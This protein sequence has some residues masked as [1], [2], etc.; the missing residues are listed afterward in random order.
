ML[1]G[2][3]EQRYETF[4]RDGV[5]QTPHVVGTKSHSF[6]KLVTPAELA[7]AFSASA[8]ELFAETGLIYVPIADR[9]RLSADMD[10]NYMM[11]ARRP[12]A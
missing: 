5:L 4:Q 3:D 1:V 10:V 6:D 9:W 11:A 2:S 8:L 7:A 12:T